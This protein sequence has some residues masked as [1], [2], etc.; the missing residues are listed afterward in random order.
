MSTTTQSQQLRR[1]SSFAP[2]DM[3]RFFW[4]QNRTMTIL[5]FASFITMVGAFIGMAVDPRMVLEQ[6]T[7]TKTAKFSISF[8]FYAPTMIWMFSYLERPRIKGFVLHGTAALL[9]VEL[10]LIVIQGMR[11][12]RMHFNYTSP[13]NATLYNIMTVSIIIFYIVSIIGGIF[14]VMTRLT[15]RTYTWSMRTGMV[16]MLIG[17][18][19]GFLMT[20]PSA[21]QMAVFESGS[22]PDF[23]GAH[24]VGAPDGSAGIPFFGWSVNYGD[25]R[26]AHFIGIHGAQFMLLVGWLVMSGGVRFGWS[27]RTRLSL[28]WG[29][30]LSY[31][32]LVTL[33]TWQALRGQ[34]L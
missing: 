17:F 33:V 8:M 16:L 25:L 21:D 26:I 22:T 12:E 7:W 32:G 1:I 23:I 24:T 4:E 34:S 15:D 30:A 20:G 14:L 18:G 11:G 29:A 19:L 13:L 9:L 5:F 6:S 3:L 28:V 27:E 10:A 2:A 31:G